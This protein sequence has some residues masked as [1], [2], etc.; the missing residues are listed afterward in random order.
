MQKAQADGTVLPNLEFFNPCDFP[1]LAAERA[2]WCVW[3]SIARV[4]DVQTAGNYPLLDLKTA[5]N[6]F[7]WKDETFKAWSISWNG[8]SVV[9]F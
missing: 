5:G 4:Y 8:V 7:G 2:A 3:I 1:R 6:F 9:G